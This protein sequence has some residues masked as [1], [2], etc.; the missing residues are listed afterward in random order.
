MDPGDIV[1][2]GYDALSARYDEVFGGAGKY[3][4][5]LDELTGRL[6]AGC[7]VLDLGCGSGL[8]VAR[9][10]TAA[11]YQ[12]TG[13]DF[14]EV[15]IARARQH[16]PAAQFLCADITAVEFGPASFDAVLSFFALIHLPLDEQPALLARAAGW[17]RPGGLLVATTGHEAWTG[18]EDNWMGG[19]APMWWSHADAASYRDWIGAAGLTVERE[20]FLTEGDGGH[21]LFWARKD[22][23]YSG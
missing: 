21:A 14:S 7:A 1:R 17:L 13:V 3:E 16:A 18:T 12:V 11:G 22:H 20:D 6:P 8:P 9:V 2:R 10:L 23:S 4:E 15:Q 5:L 19:G